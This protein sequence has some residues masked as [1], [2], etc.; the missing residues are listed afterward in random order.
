MLRSLSIASL[1]AVP[2]DPSNAVA[3]DPDAAILGSRLF[4]DT[5]LSANGEVSCASCHRPELGFTDGLQKGKGIGQ[6]R[7]N[8]RSIVGA[9][10][11]PWQYWD[12]R[13]DSLWSQALSPLEDPAEHG[14]NRMHVARFVTADPAYRKEY[15]ALFGPAPD[16]SD[17]GRFPPGAAPVDDT[18]LATAW[19]G[20]SE[21]DRH[22]VNTVYSNIGKAI[23]AYER[24]LLP[25][26]TRFDRY[27]DAVLSGDEGKQGELFDNDE[28]LGLQ[29]FIGEARCTECHNGPLLT[30]DE[31]HNT[32]VL[33]FPGDLPERGRVAGVRE[34]LSD[35]FN[36]LGDYS[37]DPDRRCDELR[38]VRTGSELIGATRTPSLRNVSATAP[39]MHRGQIATLAE[40][41]DHYNRAPDAMIGHNE[42]KPLELD[43]PDLRRLEA[44]LRTLDDPG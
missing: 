44:F 12:G 11:S 34:V 28:V 18:A 4:F 24:T 30:N 29:L 38:Y 36:C 42:A 1:P 2:P 22:V 10:Y 32:G 39:Y 25:Q 13:R 23:A 35:E 3:D 31:F 16:L 33:S 40:V 21:A 14:S 6:S 37:D 15:E 9:A 5:R 26:E 43:R 27:V 20:M 8:T 19:D 17:T 7:R 41:L